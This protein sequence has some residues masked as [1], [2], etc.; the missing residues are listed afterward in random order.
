MP[1]VSPMPPRGYYLAHEVGRLA[2]VS[3]NTIGQWARNGYIQSSQSSG[4]P[5]VYSFQDVAEAMVV[6]ELLER[7]VRYRDIKATIRGLRERW[8]WDWPLTRASLATHKGRVV[9]EADQAKYDIG[10]LGWQQIA[11]EEKD[12]DRIVGL[13]QRGGWA[14][15]DVPDL[16]HIEVTPDRLSGRPTIRG[17]RVPA[18]KV[19][20][21]MRVKGGGEIL[22]DDYGLSDDEIRDA[23][24]WWKA[25]SAYE[26]AAA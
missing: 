1:K 22:R 26:S 11:I 13:L 9:A 15:R 20:R 4:R 3:G 19:A 2:G 21:L 12:L 16:Q 17:R 8:G 7:G 23:G 5:R 10:K 14:A 25:S 24:R 6:H 18:E